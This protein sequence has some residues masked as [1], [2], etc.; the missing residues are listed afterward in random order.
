MNPFIKQ[1]I[2]NK[3][4][5]LTKAELLALSEQH[6]MPI[7]EAQA[8]KVLEIIQSNP[9]DVGNKQ[10]INTLI[11]RLKTEVDPYVSQLVTE[12]LGQYGHLLNEL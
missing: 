7:N 12:L 1:M 3:V 4:N 6:Q 5:S 11:N 8:E 2:N 10:Q 9:V